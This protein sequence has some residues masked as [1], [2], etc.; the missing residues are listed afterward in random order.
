[1]M[2]RAMGAPDSGQSGKRQAK[3][4]LRREFAPWLSG[5]IAEQR[6]LLQLMGE[7]QDQMETAW[8][9][10]RPLLDAVCADGGE[11]EA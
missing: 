4:L 8:R 3:L 1:M 7:R 5:R 6:A 10:A 2:I 9:A 11:P